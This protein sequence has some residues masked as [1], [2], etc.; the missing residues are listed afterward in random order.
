MDKIV[1]GTFICFCG[2]K[3]KHE[4]TRYIIRNIIYF[5]VYFSGRVPRNQDASAARLYQGSYSPLIIIIPF[6]VKM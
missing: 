6:A 5:I 1:R 2:V 3:C 4:F